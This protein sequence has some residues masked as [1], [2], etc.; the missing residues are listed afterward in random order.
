MEAHGLFAMP[1]VGFIGMIVIG[2]LAGYI[3]E[4][5]T[6]SDHGLLTNFLVGIAGSFLGGTLARVLSIEFY[7]WLGNLIVASIGAVIVIWLW[8]KLSN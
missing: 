6:A 4:K 5:I 2:V 3:A 7:G 8:R 1:G